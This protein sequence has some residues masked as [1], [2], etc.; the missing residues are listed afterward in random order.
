M[1]KFFN[2]A[3]LC[4]PEEH[5]MVDPLLRL[6]D[7]EKLI[8]KKLYFTIHAPRQTGKTTYLYALAK[9]LNSERKYIS[10][11]V[12]FEQAGYSSITVDKANEILIHSVYQASTDQLPEI[13]RPRNPEEKQYLNL[14]DYLKAWA[15]AQTK[16]IV[17]LIDE[18]DALLD[19]VLISVLRQ[20][21]D[22]YQS[23]PRH[24]PSSVALVG[25]R[26]VRDY[27]VKVRLNTQSMGT[28]SP[29]NVKA[30]SLFMNNFSR[31][32]VFQL[33]EQHTTETRQVFPQELKEEIYELTN[34][35]PWLTNALANQVVSEIL[36]DD[37][38]KKITWEIVQE[39]KQQLILQRDT[40]LDS[41]VDKLK[42]ERVKT[43]VQAII[44]GDNISFDILD[45][46][47]V[48]VRDLGIVSSTSPLKFANRI[49]A[50]IVPR[51]MASPIQESIPEEIQT[52]WFLDKSGS[53]NMEK[54]LKEFQKFYRRNSGSWLERYE[55]KESAHHLLLMAFLQRLVNAGGEIIREMALGNGRIDMMVKFQKQEFAM[56]LKIKRDSYTIEDGKKQ[57]NRYL[58]TLGLKQGY[59]IIFDPGNASWEEKLY[60]KPITFKNKKIIMVGL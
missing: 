13:H 56:E 48:Y 26:D 15:R 52:P 16:P 38:S 58:D 1:N 32:E 18:I 4:F 19:D 47:I 33:L 49:Y 3:G 10:L 28:A 55:Y 59:L 46:D 29:F 39:A 30:K 31:E 57:L 17:L 14:K 5:Y 42:E 35:Q 44:N 50:E 20:F 12:S 37:Y 51:V 21:R 2:T 9:K 45:D 24:F 60:Y 8:E 6:K 7:V 27:R 34:G 41:L 25:L 43:I 11:V 22:G 40:H 23:R 54:V 36:K 53:L